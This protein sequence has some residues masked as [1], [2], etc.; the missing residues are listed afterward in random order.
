ME[1]VRYLRAGSTRA[2]IGVRE[3]RDGLRPLEVDSLATLLGWPLE[4]LRAFVTAPAGSPETEAVR[5]LAP[6][7]GLTEV[8]A[9]GVTYRRSREAR[10]EESAVS[11]VYDRV[12]DADRPE[13]FFKAP[14]WRTCGDGDLVGVRADSAIDVPE[15]ELA[16]V[17]NTFA[18]VVGYTVCDDVSSRSIEGENPLYL[19]QAKIY[20]GSCALGPGIRPVWEIEDTAAL[21]ISI[22]V[23][24]AD[25]H[26]WQDHISTETLHRDL[27]QLVAYL[28]RATEFPH[29][30]VLSTGTGLV[31]DL[32]FSLTDGDEIDIDIS[33]VGTLHNIVATG[34]EPFRWLTDM[35]VSARSAPLTNDG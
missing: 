19:P 7:D 4:R 13:L 21:T 26:V 16:L 2:V 17:V 20:A 29:G 27:T 25:V 23:R 12:Y 28:F 3:D 10:M 22:T 35:A 9:A 11:D 14:A 8:W 32:T 24:R 34:S 15:P 6:V 5:I 30:A 33:G 18:E 31:P 1:I